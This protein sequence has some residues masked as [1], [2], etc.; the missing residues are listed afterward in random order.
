MG[1]AVSESETAP[2]L[3][4]QTARD[5]IGSAKTQ[6]QSVKNICEE[7]KDQQT[8]STRS[9]ASADKGLEYF[10]GT[11]SG[12]DGTCIG[13]IEGSVMTWASDSAPSE[14][15]LSPSGEL[16]VEV[17]GEFYQASLKD[18]CL[19]FSDGDVW[20]KVVSQK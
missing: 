1:K 7:S 15:R 2:T 6:D 10:S 3:L 13:Q 20:K 19:H 14:V 12:V 5:F 8:L 11:W 9:H 18:D 17:D 16:M 4:T